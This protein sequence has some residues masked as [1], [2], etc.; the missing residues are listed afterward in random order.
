MLAWGFVGAAVLMIGAGVIEAV[1]GVPAEQERLEDIA[2]ASLRRGR[3][4]NRIARMRAEART[5][6]SEGATG[7]SGLPIRRTA[8]S[9]RTTTARSGARSG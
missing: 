6:G 3:R 5:A 8:A 1:I 2:G 9:R 4:R 7:L